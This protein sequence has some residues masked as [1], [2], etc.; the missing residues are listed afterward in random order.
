S[1]PGNGRRATRPHRA[2]SHTAVPG[3]RRCPR[4]RI[5]PLRSAA[6]SAACRH[7]VVPW[8]AAIGSTS[9]PELQATNMPLAPWWR[10]TESFSLFRPFVR[11]RRQQQPIRAL[12]HFAR[13]FVEIAA[14]RFQVLADRIDTPGQRSQNRAQIVDRVVHA[15]AVF[16]R[17]AV[18]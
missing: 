4:L 13:K 14:G 7:A 6:A 15:G 5:L 3:P 11:F 18:E 16:A 9:P 12:A 1:T 17:D 2:T 10:A 8:L